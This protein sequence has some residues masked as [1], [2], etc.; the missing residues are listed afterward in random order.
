MAQ[1]IEMIDPSMLRPWGRNARVIPP[2]LTGV[3]S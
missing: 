2:F 3:H 1:T